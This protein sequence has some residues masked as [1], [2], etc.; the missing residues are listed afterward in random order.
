MVSQPAGWCELLNPQKPDR[1]RV[2]AQTPNA[3]G[4]KH[5]RCGR[6]LLTEL[7]LLIAGDRI[8][9]LQASDG[10]GRGQSDRGRPQLH[11]AA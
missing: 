2:V 8:A 5:A 4:K 10:G 6:D 1:R 3:P 7:L 11:H 9:A